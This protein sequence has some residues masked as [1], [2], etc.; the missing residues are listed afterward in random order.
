MINFTQ[1]KQNV[2]LGLE[3]CPHCKDA[4]FS[5]VEKNISFYFVNVEKDKDMYKKT[6]ADAIKSN[7]DMVT[8]PVVYSGG[9]RIGGNDDL[10]NYLKS[11]NN[12]QAMKEVGRE[13]DQYLCVLQ[14]GSGE[15]ID[16]AKEK[17]KNEKTRFVLQ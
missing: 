4:V 16:I 1:T 12:I 15:N 2:I 3:Y 17:M 14:A 8:F 6:I 5:L 7:A 9:V 11:E 10:Q 13:N